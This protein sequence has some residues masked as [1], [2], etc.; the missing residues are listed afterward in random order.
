[1]NFAGRIRDFFTARRQVS[2][3]FFDE[4]GDLLV[5]GD[6]GA[7]PAMDLV[8]KLEAIS[9]K[10]KIGD[11]SELKERFVQL[12]SDELLSSDPD[13]TVEQNSPAVILLLGVNGVGK[14][15]TAAKLASR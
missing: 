13:E 8:E 12:L 3:D 2:Q 7:A 11:T 10:E 9:R 1:M 15:T 5:E 6:F 14:T 4:L